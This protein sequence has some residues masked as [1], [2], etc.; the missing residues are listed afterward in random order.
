MSLR[1]VRKRLPI[2]DALP[3]SRG[4]QFSATLPG[5]TPVPR[6]AVWELTLACD[7]RCIHCGPRAGEA[8]GDEL[9]TSE[10]LA[11]VD[12][13]AEMGVG[14]VVLIGGEAYLRHDFILIVR[15]IRERGMSATM[16]TGGYGLTRERAEALVEA[17]IESVS[18]SIDGLQRSH[19]LVR[20][21]KDSWE[22]AFR[23]L[24]Y[25]REAGAGVAVNSQINAYTRHELEALLP[26]IAAEGIHSWQL[27][28]TVPHGNAADNPEIVMEPYM[29][30]ELFETIDRLVDQANALGVRIWPANSLGY[31]GPYEHK[32]RALQRKRTGHFGGCEAGKS[33]IGIESNGAI[34]NCPSLGGPTNVAGSWRDEGLAALWGKPQISSLRERTRKDL[35]G[36]C[37]ECYYGD[38]C[39]GG[40]TA[41]SEPLLGR[42]GNN[43][44]CHHRAL[45]M[46]RRGLRER[47]ELVRA[48]PADGFAFALFRVVREHADPQQRAKHG[49]PVAIEEPRVSR[50]E[51]WTGPGKPVDSLGAA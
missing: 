12:D 17:G 18:L 36:F 32:L 27:Q 42:P 40:C 48:A 45:E 25:L 20:N 30:L 33:T 3:A 47:I 41:V 9:T 11:L 6:L 1:Q 23:A 7:Q 31:F 50:L 22:H 16:T 26:V 29:L 39:R 24:R 51:A 43:P 44:F 35:W 15:R 37:G 14:E 38:L 13:L 46:D 8:R 19:D 2:V 34:K 5:E 4:R 10:A 21:T 49:G 28:I